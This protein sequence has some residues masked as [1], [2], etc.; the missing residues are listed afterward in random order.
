MAAIESEQADFA[1]VSTAFESALGYLT[2]LAQAKNARRM[3]LRPLHFY[4]T[5]A[6]R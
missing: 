4:G 6:M 1:R 2:H 3:S 5:S